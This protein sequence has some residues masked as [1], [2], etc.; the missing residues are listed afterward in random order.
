[1]EAPSPF[2]V[3]SQSPQGRREKGGLQSSSLALLTPYPLLTAS[4]PGPTAVVQVP[5]TGV[6]G[7]SAK[8][9]HQVCCPMPGSPR[10]APAPAF[11]ACPGSLEAPG[12]RSP[13]LQSG[14]GGAEGFR[15][16]KAGQGWLPWASASLVG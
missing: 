11:L 1:M 9:L 10:P 4:G 5:L 13:D 16:S 15:G 7:R 3:P 12:E 2:P 14:S 6:R 8:A